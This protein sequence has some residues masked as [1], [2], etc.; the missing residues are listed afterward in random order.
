MLVGE[1]WKISTWF[2]A[3]PAGS[4]GKEV[5]WKGIS[6]EGAELMTCHIPSAP[7]QEMLDLLEPP[8]PV[9]F[10][11]NTIKSPVRHA[12]YHGRLQPSLSWN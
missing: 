8:K 4:L 7:E 1:D 3:L 2:F 10:S 9:L 12:G 5:L 11:G 6:T